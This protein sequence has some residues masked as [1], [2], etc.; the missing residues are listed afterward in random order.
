MHYGLKGI[1]SFF[2]QNFVVIQCNGQ[3]MV[4]DATV[5]CHSSQNCVIFQWWPSE[6]YLSAIKVIKIIKI[7]LL[8]PAGGKYVYKYL[9]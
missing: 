6:V 7:C 2:P 8:L 3:T 9:L 5:Q 1:I 4:V